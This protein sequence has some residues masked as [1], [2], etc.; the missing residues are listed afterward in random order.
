MMCFQG[1]LQTTETKKQAT[2]NGAVFLYTCI[3]CLH[4]FATG[5]NKYEIGECNDFSAN[6]KFH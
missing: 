1:C 2:T 3:L 5:T 4:F 6:V